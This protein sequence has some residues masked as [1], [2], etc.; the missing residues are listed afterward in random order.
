MSIPKRILDRHIIGAAKVLQRY[1]YG[2]SDA[3]AYEMA[4]TVLQGAFP[5]A[6]Y[7]TNSPHW[8]V[9]TT[10]GTPVVGWIGR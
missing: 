10:I 6:K 7:P 4:I 8:P 3:T 5:K 1:D 2:L 9:V